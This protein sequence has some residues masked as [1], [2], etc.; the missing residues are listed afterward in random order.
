MWG[1]NKGAPTP[2]H[3]S[4]RHNCITPSVLHYGEKRIGA[5]SQSK[6]IGTMTPIISS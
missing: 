1:A 4:L 6:A 2:F 3:P 5:A